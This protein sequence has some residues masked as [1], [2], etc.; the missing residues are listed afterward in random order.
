MH[1]IFCKNK[2]ILVRE[3]S[4]DFYLYQYIKIYAVLYIAASVYTG[5]S[6]YFDILFFIYYVVKLYIMLYIVVVVYTLL[7]IY[8]ELFL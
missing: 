7:H 3:F 5:T 6:I 8:T 4:S 1:C 2:L